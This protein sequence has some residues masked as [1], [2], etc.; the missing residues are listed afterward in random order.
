MS[1]WLKYFVEKTQ[2]PPADTLDSVTVST[3][4]VPDSPVL[5]ENSTWAEQYEERAAI[6]EYDAHLPRM[7]AEHRAKLEVLHQY[8]RD[9][10]PTL[11]AAFERAI[12]QPNMH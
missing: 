2:P 8:M 5:E 3:L 4:S 9:T 10:T 11:L 1:K 7:E 6:L 12:T